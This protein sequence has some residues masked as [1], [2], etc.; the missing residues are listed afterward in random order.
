MSIGTDAQAGK[1]VGS[2]DGLKL[3]KYRVGRDHS[4]NDLLNISNWWLNSE[5]TGFGKDASG[6]PNIHTST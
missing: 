2:A 4:S 1:I 5:R 3:K 6:T